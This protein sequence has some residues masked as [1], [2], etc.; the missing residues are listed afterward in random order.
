MST[1]NIYAH[2]LCHSFEDHEMLLG[3]ISVYV[4]V[5]CSRIN[6]TVTVTTFSGSGRCFW[7]GQCLFDASWFTLSPYFRNKYLR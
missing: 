2:T 4:W 5:D 3:H 7:L 1:S 6:V